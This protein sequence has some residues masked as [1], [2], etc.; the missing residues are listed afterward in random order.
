MCACACQTVQQVHGMV[1]LDLC[2][3]NLFVCTTVVPRPAFLLTC[4]F[5]A[6]FQCQLT[7][8]WFSDGQILRCFLDRPESAY[9]IQQIGE[10]LSVPLDLVGACGCFCL[11]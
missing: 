1:H 9:S 11:L 5:E 8:F 7:T 4:V 3:E 6:C 2:L 10:Q